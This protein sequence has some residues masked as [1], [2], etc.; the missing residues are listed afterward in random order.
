[1]S[2]A[3]HVI[4]VDEQIVGHALSLDARYEFYTAHP[5][6]KHLDGRRFETVDAIRTA[7]AKELGDTYELTRS[8]A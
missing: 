6:L 1:M 7:A 2:V 8:T 4:T 5:K 3:H